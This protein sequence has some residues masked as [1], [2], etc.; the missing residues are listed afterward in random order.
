MIADVNS[1]YS[2]FVS[3]KKCRP[4][5]GVVVQ[6]ERDGDVLRSVTLRTGER[7]SLGTWA[8]GNYTLVIGATGQ[9]VYRIEMDFR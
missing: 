2:L 8:T 1:Q 6:L 9:D 3:I 4:K 7:S 5:D